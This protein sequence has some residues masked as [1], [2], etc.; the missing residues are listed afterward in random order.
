MQGDKLDKQDGIEKRTKRARTEQMTVTLRRTGGIYTVQSESGNV[1]RVDV[2]RKGCNCPDQQK[3]AVERCKHLRRVDMEIQNRTVPT[4]DGRLPERPRADGGVKESVRDPSQAPTSGRIEGP[5]QELDKHG[6]PTG[7]SYVRCRPCGREAM[8][9]KDLE[10][11]CR[12]S[13][14]TGENTSRNQ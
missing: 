13:S 6:N 8:R 14:Q 4:P 3:T 9:E 10:D 7:E 2:L 12:G 11:C 5:L 1:Y